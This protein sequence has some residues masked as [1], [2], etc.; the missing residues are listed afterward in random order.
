MALRLFERYAILLHS[1]KNQILMEL[2]TRVLPVPI[3]EYRGTD[4][5]GT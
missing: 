4:G 2:I 3:D 1:L 5:T